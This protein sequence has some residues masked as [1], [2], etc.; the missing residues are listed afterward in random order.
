MK[1]S[2]YDQS[3]EALQEQLRLLGEP[4]YRSKQVFQWLYRRDA[5]SFQAMTDLS[6]SLRQ[7]LDERFNCG[8]TELAERHRAEDDG[9]TKCVIRLSDGETVE[10]VLIPT[11]TRLTGCI[12]TQV[13]CK[14][15]CTFCA[16]GIAGFVRNL[17][18]GEI[19]QQVLWLNRLAIAESGG[20][21]L[22]HIVFMGIGEPLDNY[23]ALRQ[24]IGVLTSPSAVGM[25]SRRLTVSTCGV[26]TK[27]DRLAE[28]GVRVHLS[29]SLHGA[30]DR[31][32]G[33]LMPVNRAYPLQRLLESCQRYRRSSRH[34][35]TFEYILLEGKND[36]SS[37]AERLA[38]H[39]KQLGAKVNLIP[40][41]P[42]DGLAFRTPSR[43]RVEAFQRRLVARGVVATVRWSRGGQVD[44]ACG[45]LRI[46]R[47]DGVAAGTV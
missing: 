43:E 3:L 12:S 15:A 14:F 2:I 47:R 8:D 6:E 18:A 30:T 37:D 21:W 46:R 10:S 35:L 5:R 44:A 9:A 13:G 16:S 38:L 45:Q 17:S 28:D 24:A 40:Y 42:V 29:I 20:S 34:D 7:Q 39:A 27:I 19:I 36:R 23:E 33:A 1:P 11:P 26:A 41:N 31:V 22:T 32:R 25:S 4:S